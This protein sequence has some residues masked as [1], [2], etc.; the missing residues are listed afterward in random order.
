MKILGVKFYNINSLRGQWEIR[1][2]QP[3]LSDTGLFA[4]VGPNGS[5]KSSILDAVTLGLYGATPR[6]KDPEHGVVSYLADESFTEV[7]FAVG[8]D[9]YRSSWRLRRGTGG[10]DEPEMWL[11]GGSDG[12]ALLAERVIPVRNR[13]AELTGLDFK[14]FCRSILLAQGEFAAFLGA[15]E[16]ERLDILR[17]IVGSEMMEELA[18]TIRSRATAESAKLRRLKEST[19]APVDPSRIEEV[20]QALEAIEQEI[21]ETERDL[22]D[23]HDLESWLERLD[24][25]ESDRRGVDANLVEAEARCA[26]LERRV[27]E[28]DRARRSNAWREAMERLGEQE[29]EQT[30]SRRRAAEL[31]QGNQAAQARLQELD[32][33]L[34]RSR[35]ELDQARARLAERLRHLKLE[36]QAECER[37]AAEIE[38]AQTE[39]QKRLTGCA[40]DSDLKACLPELRGQINRLVD[41]RRRIEDRRHRHGEFSRTEQKVARDLAGAEQVGQTLREKIERV[42]RRRLEREQHLDGLLEDKKPREWRALAR[43]QGKKLAA[44]GKLIDLARR[45]QALGIKPESVAEYERVKAE[46]SA[47]EQSLAREET[48][49]VEFAEQIAQRDRVNRLQ[50]E[51]AAVHAGRPCPLCGSVH[52]PY[53]EE[54]PPDFNELDRAELTCRQRM[55]AL[56]RRLD[57]LRKNSAAL[58]R[59]A[60]DAAKIQAAWSAVCARA[61][62]AWAEPS[63]ALVEDERHR[64][65]SAIKDC[66]SRVRAARR[67][68]WRGLW[69]NFS[70]RRKEAE[71]S[72]RERQAG[73][74]RDRHAQALQALTAL[75]NE[76]QALQTTES[77]LQSQLDGRLAQFSERAPAAGVETALLGRLHE[78]AG[79]VERLLRERDQLGARWKDLERER[80][81]AA[82]DL[83]RNDGTGKTAVGIRNLDDQV[84][85]ITGEQAVLEQQA[86]ALRR[87]LADSEPR[88]SRLRAESQ[89]L[90]QSRAE[91]RQQILE[92]ASAAGLAGLD[93]IRAE[94]A[95]VDEAQ[96]W[97]RDLLAAEQALASLR[98]QEENLR[99]EIEALRAEPKTSDSPR[100]IRQRREEKL[101]QREVLRE[102]K[103]GFGDSLADLKAARREHAEVL[104]ALAEQE[105]TWAEAMAEQRLLDSPDSVEIRSR[106]EQL[107]LDRL[108]G[109]ANS[110]LAEL[111]RRYQLH[112]QDRNGRA[113][114]VHDSWQGGQVRTVQTLSG[115]ETFV[116][117]LCMA[118]GL[119][120]MAG[121]ERKIRS[122]FLDEGFGALDDEN[123]YQVIATLKALRTDGKTIG[124]ISHV[125]R[126][127]DE[128]PTQVRLE[129]LSGGLSQIKVRA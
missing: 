30:A 44:C 109:L 92:Q 79:E 37:R 101:R 100:V 98:F 78:R 60:E 121:R 36:R 77:R 70:L 35:V 99:R 12:G 115:G 88:L 53:M 26:E 3:P 103:A 111:S 117:S 51:R 10:A 43:G 102:T 46:I 118:L 125:K 120:E 96:G 19:V 89:R 123:L 93:E 22:G 129:K 76:L 128:I 9:R 67:H 48:F 82:A 81:A 41:I 84:R 124:V 25:L 113:L 73:Q 85:R 52:H 8:A 80:E 116:L 34:E 64:L 31:E 65:K 114:V 50:P 58:A 108:L 27:P 55:E 23:L 110:H 33:R 18:Q 94:L 75:N 2:D 104:Q 68:K 5:G 20:R 86:Q 126:L 56:N 106:I 6:Q 127:A 63:L 90:E 112:A 59:R 17:T 13:V 119:A 61:G 107:M 74:L 40:V 32:E 29:L 105:K 87:E 7:N 4:I 11:M 122:L 69:T 49:F 15:S 42:R 66:R 16:G 21:E 72:R 38:R 95:L 45:C 54:A 24:R 83:E 91:L 71:F 39:I 28:A 97:S 57:T 1:F 47:L 62:F 14:R